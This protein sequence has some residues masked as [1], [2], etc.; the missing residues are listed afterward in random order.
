MA[1]IFIQYNYNATGTAPSSQSLDD[2]LTAMMA[3]TSQAYKK[4]CKGKVKIGLVAK[5]SQDVDDLWYED[6]KQGITIAL[7]GLCR[8]RKD[9]LSRINFQLDPRSQR[10][11]LKGVV[12]L[13]ARGEENWIDMLEGS[14]NLAVYEAKKD[15][16]TIAND[17]FGF[18]PLYWIQSSGSI[19]FSSKLSSILKSG[20]LDNPSFDFVSFAEHL[21]FKY[22][23]S[24]NSYIKGVSVLPAATK[25][26]VDTSGLST[27]KYFRITDYLNE[28]AL[29]SKDS[30]D[31]FDASLNE[32]CQKIMSYSKAEV[33]MSLTGGWDSRLVLSYLIKDHRDCLNLY[34]FGAP[35]SP[36]ITVPQRICSSEGL[37]YI[38][39]ILDDKYLREDFKKAAHDTVIFSEGARNYKRAHYLY[40]IRKIASN[41][42]DLITGIFGDE[43]IKV[44][45]PQGGAVISKNTVRLLLKGFIP[46]AIIREEIEAVSRMLADQY[47]LDASV[48]KEKLLSRIEGISSDYRELSNSSCRHLVF[49]FD[50]NLRKYFGA[51]AGSYND[52]VNCYS[53]FTDR[54]F[55]MNYLKTS[56]AAHRH[57]FVSSN[58]LTKINSTRLYAMLVSKQYSPLLDYPSSRGYSMKQ[59]MSYRGCLSIILFRYMRNSKSLDAFNTNTTNALFQE[60]MRA[61]RLSVNNKS[62]VN[63]YKDD[64][65]SLMYWAKFTNEKYNNIRISNF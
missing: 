46:D 19:V 29:S 34:S 57:P 22:T 13:I 5:I 31:L 58:I 1:G 27:V 39:I 33:N 64:L 28:K 47:D 10:D 20:V 8:I 6:S 55:F 48:L 30:F 36:D 51:E 3:I 61:R 53:P 50:N 23:I 26:M 41:S 11:H 52:Y 9:Y 45:R 18:F 7:D 49:R 32:A 2:V 43:V 60:L 37:S 4:L 54:P 25:V 15:Q 42:I 14:F 44:G 56:Y 17:I 65:Y 16:L 38:P 63:L 59:A 12:Q 35:K 24:S 40:S 21:L 62:S